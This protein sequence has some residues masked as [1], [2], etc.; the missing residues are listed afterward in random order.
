MAEDPEGSTL[1]GC[2][3]ALDNLDLLK[4]NFLYIR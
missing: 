2:A 3:S 4:R 1:R